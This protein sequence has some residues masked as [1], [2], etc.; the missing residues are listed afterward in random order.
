VF[1]KRRFRSAVISGIPGLPTIPA[2]LPKVQSSRVVAARSSSS[3]GF[4]M[5]IAVHE[6]TGP[7]LG[8]ALFLSLVRAKNAREM[9][10]LW[11]DEMLAR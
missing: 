8:D 5:E 3:N 2:F 11:L 7:S 10:A 4:Q 9:T 1:C 6:A